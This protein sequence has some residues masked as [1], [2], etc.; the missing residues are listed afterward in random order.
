MQ[1]ENNIGAAI[2][3]YRKEKGLSQDQLSMRSG[4]S[5]N[6]IVKLERKYVV[7]NPTIDTLQR[8]AGVLEVP[9]CELLREPPYNTGI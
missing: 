2:R 4:V 1:Q 5:Y 8:I 6:T 3:H 9:I 7:A